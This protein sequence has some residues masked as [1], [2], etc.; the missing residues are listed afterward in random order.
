MA[1]LPLASASSPA[2]PRYHYLSAAE[3]NALQQEVSLMNAPQFLEKMQMTPRYGDPPLWLGPHTGPVLAAAFATMPQEKA[4]EL[5]E[6][7][8]SLEDAA[9]PEEVVL[10]AASC[11][12]HAATRGSHPTF[13]RRLEQELK[14]LILSP[15]PIET[16]DWGCRRKAIKRAISAILRLWSGTNEETRWFKGLIGDST[17]HPEL[18]CELLAQLTTIL[19][20]P[21][22][23]AAPTAADSMFAPQPEEPP[24]PKPL[25]QAWSKES[26]PD[27]LL[28]PIVK[29]KGEHRWVRFSAI[30]TLCVAVEDG[31][32]IE[33]LL[34]EIA[35]DSTE[36]SLV[37]SSA[38][39]RLAGY[40]ADETWFPG[41]FAGLATSADAPARLVHGTSAWLG[42]IVQRHPDLRPLITRF[43]ANPDGH[44]RSQYRLLEGMLYRGDTTW[45]RDHLIALASDAR[46]DW[47][48]RR[49]ALQL[50][51]ERFHQ[52][53]SLPPRLTRLA[54]DPH[55]PAAVRVVALRQI[56][57]RNRDDP[58]LKAMLIRIIKS[59]EEPGELRQTAMLYLNLKRE[60]NQWVK[61]LLLPLASAQ[62]V[63]VKVRKAAL[64]PMAQLWHEPWVAE[65]YASICT[66]KDEPEEVRLLVLEA[67][68]QTQCTEVWLKHR[69]IELAED[70]NE[71]ES[72]RRKA[73]WTMAQVWRDTNWMPEMMLKIAASTQHAVSVRHAA[74]EVFTAHYPDSKKASGVLAAILSNKEDQA[75]VRQQAARALGNLRDAGIEATALLFKTAHDASNASEVRIAAAEALAYK[76]TMLSWEERTRLLR[77]LAGASEKDAEVR[78]KA[79][80]CIARIRYG[81]SLG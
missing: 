28:L 25:I 77:F 79:A 1:A 68:Y 11:H 31:T 10:F 70:P 52:D 4:A 39:K 50:L 63:D 43:T 21:A 8:W 46:L 40:F 30:E 34:R 57:G 74:M 22:P 60:D 67:L 27:E 38:M 69:L 20:P 53:A 23:A 2:P 33:S 81:M 16:M 44:A 45:F 58:T 49:N 54:G 66:S 48:Q 13:A 15:W 9:F 76:K 29:K 3:G 41:W 32:E 17:A 5:L 59:A 18:R 62:E 64:W 55:V 26:W 36:P 6:T 24:Y 42:S 65:M 72:I 56:A 7:I 78:R 47:A 61:D 14:K 35:E 12:E 80:E 51:I 19:E 73:M 75:L 71:K 37:R